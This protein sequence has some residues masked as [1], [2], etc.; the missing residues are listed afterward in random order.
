GRDQGR[1]TAYEDGA[2][3]NTVALLPGANAETA[4]VLTGSFHT[5]RSG[6]LRVRHV[7]GEGTV[8]ADGKRQAFFPVREATLFAPRALTLFASAADGKPDH[9]A[10]VLRVRTGT[11]EEDRL[12]LLDLNTLTPRGREMTLWDGGRTVPVVAASPRGPFLAVAGNPT[13]DARD[14][15]I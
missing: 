5:D 10:V 13:G 2:L 9:V 11:R 7:L 14:H 3:N 4:S 6:Q 15:E 8:E 12:R 1:L